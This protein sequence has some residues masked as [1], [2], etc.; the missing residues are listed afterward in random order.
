MRNITPEVLPHNDVPRRT[1]LSVKLF[2]DIGRNV[3]LH[4]EFLES[5]CRNFDRILLH[6]LGHVHIFDDG[7][8][9]TGGWV[10]PRGHIFHVRHRKADNWS[11]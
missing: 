8:W 11:I 3:L 1:V 5:G 7:F 2:L 10:A 9:Y 6:L 4:R